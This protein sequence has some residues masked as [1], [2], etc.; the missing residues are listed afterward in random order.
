MTSYYISLLKGNDLLLHHS[1][2]N[3]R[4]FFLCYRNVI[5]EIW[6]E[7]QKGVAREAVKSYSRGV[8]EVLRGFSRNLV[9]IPT[10]SWA[11][12]EPKE[13]IERLVSDA[14]VAYS[15]HAYMNGR[16]HAESMQLRVRSAVSKGA[17]FISEWGTSLFHGKGTKI[18]KSESREWLESLRHYRVSHV[19]WNIS[20]KEESFS[21]L[22][23][24]SCCGP[25][26]FE[27]LTENGRFMRQV[28]QESKP[29]V[30]F[31]LEVWEGHKVKLRT[32]RVG[33]GDAAG[34]LAVDQ[35]G[36][37]CDDLG[38]DWELEAAGEAVRIKDSSGRYLAL[39]SERNAW[40]RRLNLSDQGTNWKATVRAGGSLRLAV[41]DEVPEQGWVLALHRS[42]PSDQHD[43]GSTFACVHCPAPAKY[44][45]EWLPEPPLRWLPRFHG[46]FRMHAT[47]D[48]PLGRYVT[49]G[50]ER[51]E[52]SCYASLQPIGAVW[53]AELVAP[54]LLRISELH[55]R[56]LSFHGSLQQDRL[57]ED[58]GEAYL[59][60]AG[61]HWETLW[62]LEPGSR[63]SC[64][65]LRVAKDQGGTAVGWYLGLDEAAERLLVHR[66]NGAE[67]V[68]EGPE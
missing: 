30:S 24:G 49:S 19:M 50:R 17:V 48:E 46:P 2:S 29:M 60:E 42:L 11:S 58:S 38:A 59:H 22:R 9:L 47:R 7:P 4:F 28:L 51:N 23:A 68:F 10:T 64:V 14:N 57:D 12:D 8:L 39:H 45:M 1:S 25:W 33:W 26:A 63:A 5:F 56:R 35:T 13:L 53:T 20:D 27:E 15:M 34:L 41:A 61:E 62:R 6:N 43:D 36:V 40:S 32:A 44:A 31:H 16:D 37:F 54:E 3:I 66:S 55:G 18:L 65:R 52:Q 21:A 67:F